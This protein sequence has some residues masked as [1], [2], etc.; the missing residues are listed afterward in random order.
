MCLYCVGETGGLG[1]ISVVA[2]C[3]VY[4]LCPLG[5]LSVRMPKWPSLQQRAEA[6]QPNMVDNKAA[7]ARLFAVLSLTRGAK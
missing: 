5:A 1:S 6:S 7:F 3:G 4:P 2:A